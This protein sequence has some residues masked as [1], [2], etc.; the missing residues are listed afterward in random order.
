MAEEKHEL[1]EFSK[2]V[3]SE[4]DAIKRAARKQQDDVN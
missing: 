4:A 1:N 3:R 2:D